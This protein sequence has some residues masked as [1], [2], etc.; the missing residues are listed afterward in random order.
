MNGN[1]IRLHKLNGVIIEVPIEKMSAGDTAYIK[2]VTSRSSNR[3]E[4]DVPL[5]QISNQEDRRNERHRRGEAAAEGAG[6]SRPAPTTSRPSQPPKKQTDWFEFFLNAGCDVDDCTRYGNNFQRERIEEGLISEIEPSTLRTLG[7]REGD[8]IRVMKHIRQNFAPPTPS[9]SDRDVQIASDALMARTIQEPT[10]PPPNLFTGPDGG[11]KTTRRGRPT[12]NRSGTGGVDSAALANAGAAL[13][14]QR[15]E[16]PPIVTSTSTGDLLGRSR[17]NSSVPLSSGGFDDDAWQVRPS[18]AKPVVSTAPAPTPI[19]P[20]A[21]QDQPQR[22]T[23]TGPASP[24][25]TLSYNDGLLA[26]LG[27]G[28]R[29]PSAPVS[30]SAGGSYSS[31]PTLSGPRPPIAP[32][33]INQQ[34]LAPLVPD[35]TGM[36]MGGQQQRALMPNITG[37]PGMNNPQFGGGGMPMQN[38]KLFSSAV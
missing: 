35:R 18:S 27:I 29:P 31:V 14:A 4:D 3:D 6:T 13:A 22:S 9:K 24:T 10:P 17:S 5:S 21:P 7:L 12:P 34:L 26:Q 33:P 11:L 23:S 15:T 32:L 1:K 8:I 36:F 28:A 16:T 38:R 37:Y 20:A 30:S 19:Q 2:K 25:S